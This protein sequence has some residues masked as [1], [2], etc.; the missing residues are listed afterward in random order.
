MAPETVRPPAAGQ[1]LASV[2]V[3]RVDGPAAQDLL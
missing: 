3:S 1:A 2:T